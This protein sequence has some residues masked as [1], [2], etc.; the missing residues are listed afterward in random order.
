MLGLAWL[1]AQLLSR[2][3]LR[4]DDC[5]SFPRAYGAVLGLAIGFRNDV[6]ITIP[7]F[8]L[9]LLAAR[10]STRC[11]RGG[12]AVRHL[13]LAGVG[14]VVLSIP[15]LRVYA[16]GGGASMSHA[17]FLGMMRPIDS[18]LGDQ[19]RRACMRLATVSTTRMPPP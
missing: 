16:N 5:W 14:F 3:R 4:L 2:H 7:P 6:L 13:L 10:Q 1:M 8:V 12:G 17:A 9:L 19:Q 11:T 15:V 18:A